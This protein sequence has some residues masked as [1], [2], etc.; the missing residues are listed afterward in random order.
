MFSQKGAGI[1]LSVIMEK[2]DVKGPEGD[3]ELLVLSINTAKKEAASSTEHK[4]LR[5]E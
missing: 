5:D 2:W 4:G 3:R 1:R